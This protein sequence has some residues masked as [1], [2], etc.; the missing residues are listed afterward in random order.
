MRLIRALVM[1]GAVVISHGASA[2]S[3]PAEIDPVCPNAELLGPKLLTDICWDCLFP[4]WIS[5]ANWG[6]GEKPAKAANEVL[7][8]CQDELG[9]PEVG[10]GFGLWNPARIIEL[11]RTPGCMST[12]NGTHMDIGD[13]MYGT[14]GMEPRSDHSDVVFYHYHEYVFPL[15]IMLGLFYDASCLADG[16]VDLDVFFMS[17]LDPTWSNDELAFFQHPEAALVADPVSLAACAADGARAAISEPYDEYFWCAGSWGHLYPFSGH[18]VADGGLAETTSLLASKVLAVDHRRAMAW[19]TMGKDVACEAKIDAFLP[20]TQYKLSMFFPV[21]EGEYAH[22][23]GETPW[24]WG[25][26]RKIPAV[27]EDAVWVVFRWQDCC[28]R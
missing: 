27:G 7:C 1:A 10:I 5:G 22:N 24:N 21:P 2:Q 8:I 12:L 9:V 3:V 16:Y 23:I 6:G 14:A 20:K 26:A 17:E 15:L 28:L 4:M 13:R 25:E 18:K 19:R 11:V